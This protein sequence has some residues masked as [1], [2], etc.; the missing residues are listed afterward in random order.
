VGAWRGGRSRVRD[1]DSSSERGGRALGK[2][3]PPCPAAG[4]SI[5]TFVLV[6]AS[7]FVL[8]YPRRTRARQRLAQPRRRERRLR[9]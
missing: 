4:V 8:M 9:R 7:V 5:Y 1:R 2:R 3:S 6:S